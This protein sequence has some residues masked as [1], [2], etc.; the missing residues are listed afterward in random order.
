[1]DEVLMRHPAVQ[2]VCTVGAPDDEWGEK[3]ISVV[4]PAAGHAPS[5]ALAE[6][7]QA[8]ATQHLARF[9]CPREIVF[10]SALPHTG[11]GKLQRNQVRQRFWQGRARSI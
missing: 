7:I 8:H 4:V 6:A 3:V 10:D 2:D 5:Q 11:S 9:K 1:V